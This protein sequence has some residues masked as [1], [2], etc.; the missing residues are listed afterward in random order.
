MQ[1]FYNFIRFLHPVKQIIYFIF[2]DK[3]FKG[4]FPRFGCV[5]RELPLA[6]IKV[7]IYIKVDYN[8]KVLYYENFPLSLLGLL[9]W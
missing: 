5:I 9:S 2:Q 7:M 4:N 8:N 1:K 3:V 6:E